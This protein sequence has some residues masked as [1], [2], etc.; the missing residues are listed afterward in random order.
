MNKIKC[1]KCEGEL[2]VVSV[3]AFSAHEVNVEIILGEHYDEWKRNNRDVDLFVC[4]NKLCEDFG[5]IRIA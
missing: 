4:E 1:R 5:I 3:H 2:S